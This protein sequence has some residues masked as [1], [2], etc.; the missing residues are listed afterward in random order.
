MGMIGNHM[1]FITNLGKLMRNQNT[2]YCINPDLI[3]RFLKKKNYIKLYNLLIFFLNIGR[4][5]LQH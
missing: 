1:N 2:P 3:G 5:G 4:F